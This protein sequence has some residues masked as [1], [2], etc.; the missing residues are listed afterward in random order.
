MP[1]ELYYFNNK[2]NFYEP[3][4]E[5]SYLKMAIVKDSKK[6]I[7]LSFSA[8]RILNINF[9]VA[10]YETIFLIVNSLKEEKECYEA[11]K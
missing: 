7:S 11:L 2:L 8:E 6:N 5:P 9:S 1:L 10:L 3:F 4:I